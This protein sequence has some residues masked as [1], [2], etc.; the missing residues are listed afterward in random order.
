MGEGEQMMLGTILE[1]AQAGE[2]GGYL[3]MR[4]RY[5][6]QAEESSGSESPS[7]WNDLIGW[8]EEQGEDDTQGFGLRKT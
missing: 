2:T 3:R 7:G 1:S 4:R 6:D 8:I 5:D